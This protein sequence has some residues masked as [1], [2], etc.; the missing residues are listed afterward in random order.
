MKR[1]INLAGCILVALSH[2][3][4]S[5]NAIAVEGIDKVRILTI[6]TLQVDTSYGDETVVIAVAGAV[7]ASVAAAVVTL[8]ASAVAEGIA[9]GTIG[10]TALGTI[11]AAG[12]T[13]GVAAKKATE[14]TD[15][16]VDD[17][18]ALFMSNIDP[19]KFHYVQNVSGAKTPYE[20][21]NGDVLTVGENISAFMEMLAIDVPAP[22]ANS[23]VPIV[24]ML[25]LT[26]WDSMSANDDLGVL[27]I[28]SYEHTL[29]YRP[30]FVYNIHGAKG[31]VGVATVNPPKDSEDNSSYLVTYSVEKDAGTCAG[32]GLIG[33]LNHNSWYPQAPKC[34]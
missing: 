31:Y 33:K 11:A 7:V 4:I 15:G 14:W 32:L 26:E 25:S 34:H 5:S 10:A 30:D 2:L 22:P 28:Q 27:A 29:K 1:K 21:N 6:Q 16:D 9:A 13:G 23:A 19:T 18:Q 12:V 8:G 3:F 24:A 17:L 20:M